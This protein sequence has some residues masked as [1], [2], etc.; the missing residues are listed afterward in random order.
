MHSCLDHPIHP[1]RTETD[2][3]D[4]P[5]LD[6][7]GYKVNIEKGVFQVYKSQE[8][9]EAKNP[10]DYSVPNLDTFVRDMHHL[11]A[12]IADG[13]L[14]SFCYRRLSYLQSKYQLHVLLNELRELAAQK[15]VPHRD[16]YNCRKV[17]WIEE[18]GLGCDS[19][20]L[21]W[22]NLLMFPLDRLIL[23]FTQPPA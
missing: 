6:D 15:A 20:C 8:D 14:K 17:S 21:S 9:L 18:Q 10:V 12:M 16:F 11:C 4:C 5:V 3:W 13:P 1:P 22:S 19:I 23:T 7:C 2:P